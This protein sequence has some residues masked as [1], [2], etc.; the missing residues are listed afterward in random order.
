MEDL[1]QKQKSRSRI[2]SKLP[3]INLFFLNR[4][5]VTL[6]D[7][8]LSWY[9][10]CPVGYSSDSGS[11]RLNGLC[12]LSSGSLLRGQHF[13]IMTLASK[14]RLSISRQSITSW[15]LSYRIWIPLASARAFRP[16]PTESH[17]V[18][19][20]YRMECVGDMNKL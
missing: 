12:S 13:L 20:Q 3:D 1:T 14:I 5:T 9:T 2:A 18:Y 16:E 17:L 19:T 15:A 7:L 6:F 4:L 11:S 10:P 8:D